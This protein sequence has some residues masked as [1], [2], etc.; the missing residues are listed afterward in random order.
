MNTENV[1]MYKSAFINFFGLIERYGG[2]PVHW[3]HIHGDGFIG[4]TIDMCSK[5]MTGR[6]VGMHTK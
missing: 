6:Q 4:T 3:L 1:E 5:Q 2:K